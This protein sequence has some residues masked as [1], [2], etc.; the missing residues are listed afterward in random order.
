ML[1]FQK[2]SEEAACVPNATCAWTYSST[3]PEVTNMTTAWDS[4]NQWWTVVV[5]G[6]GFTGN[7]TTT[8]LDVGGRK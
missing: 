6:T 5:T 1:V 3:T 7:T 2:V 8:V 4:S